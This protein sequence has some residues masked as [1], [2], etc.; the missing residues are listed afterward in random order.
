M[1]NRYDF[2]VVEK[3]LKTEDGVI[4]PSK[5]IVR[6][7]TNEVLSVMSNEY[8]VIR[9]SEVLNQFEKSLGD[10]LSNRKVTLC[11][12]GAILFAR[13]ETPKIESIEVK[14][15]DIV[16]FGVEAFNSYDGSLP[17][18]FVF[19]ALRLVCTNGMTIPKSIARISVRHIGNPDITNIREDF[20][21]RLPLY[22]KTANKWREWADITPEE[23][24]VDKFFK[25]MFGKRHQKA[26][27]ELYKQSEDKT[28]WGL[29]NMFTRYSTHDIKVRKNNEQNKRLA[30]WNFE[31][32]VI[33]RMYNY[34]W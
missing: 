32:K 30:Q 25:E 19:T 20:A 13:Y 22:L 26:F 14:K 1:E 23:V 31:Q 12:N 16:K 28:L 33:N 18:G 29:Y 15:D 2:E 7:D 4:V 8:K 17:V 34:N 27:A 9:H 6:A 5:A 10:E 3:R 11:K 24:V 21:K